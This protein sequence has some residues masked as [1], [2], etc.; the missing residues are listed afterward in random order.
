MV[1][2]GH[3]TLL[4]F[5]QI[6]YS[7]KLKIL[8]CVVITFFRDFV[9]PSLSYIDIGVLK[10]KV[11]YCTKNINVSMSNVWT[12]SEINSRKRI[13]SLHW[14]NKQQNPFINI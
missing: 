4:Y 11:A 12:I 10:H 6:V 3:V 5:I 1:I 2:I 9:F 7:I 13:K 14:S 8:Q